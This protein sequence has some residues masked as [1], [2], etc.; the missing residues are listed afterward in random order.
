VLEFALREALSLGH[1]YIGT[2]HIL[3]GLVREDEG[4]AARVLLHFDAD[5]EKIRNEVI[6]MLSGPAGRR[7]PAGPQAAGPQDASPANPR[8]PHRKSSPCTV[9]RKAPCEQPFP[10][11][12]AA[13]RWRQHAG[14]AAP[15]GA[16]CSAARW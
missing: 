4:V 9:R 15:T 10:R 16:W 6:Q 3:L 11:D 7:R 2:E 14:H 5:C 8:P 1:N 13:R 12:Q